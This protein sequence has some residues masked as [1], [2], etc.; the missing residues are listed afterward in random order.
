MGRGRPDGGVADAGINRDLRLESPQ[1]CWRPGQPRTAFSWVSSGFG[2][3]E[4]MG[5]GTIAHGT[6]SP[7]PC[8][9]L[10]LEAH[11]LLPSK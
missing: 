9:V 3:T 6:A 7:H 4:L 8:R 10:A 1:A 5:N 2:G 11:Q